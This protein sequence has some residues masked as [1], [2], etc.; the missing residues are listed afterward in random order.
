MVTA[1][2]AHA[3]IHIL[4]QR[5]IKRSKKKPQDVAYTFVYFS[6]E[7]VCFFKWPALC[8]CAFFSF[9]TVSVFDIPPTVFILS[10]FVLLIICFSFHLNFLFMSS[11]LVSTNLEDTTH[12]LYLFRLFFSFLSFPLTFPPCSL[13]F[14]SSPLNFLPLHLSSLCHASYLGLVLMTLTTGKHC[15]SEW[16]WHFFSLI[17]YHQSCT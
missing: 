4:V 9:V 8:R 17:A 16:M 7:T 5:R 13:A 11:V 6:K 3:C 12:W 2:L 1:S 10:L 14:S 15:S